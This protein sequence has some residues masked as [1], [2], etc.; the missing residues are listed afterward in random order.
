MNITTEKNTYNEK[1]DTKLLDIL[2]CPLTKTKLHY[3][4]SKQELISEE[5][6]LAYPIRNGIPVMLIEEARDILK[7]EK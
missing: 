4:E 2:V 6:G 1:L 7:D 5:A 3:D